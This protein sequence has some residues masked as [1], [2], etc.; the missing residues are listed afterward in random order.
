MLQLRRDLKQPLCL[1]SQHAALRAM[2]LVSVFMQSLQIKPV[3]S[4]AKDCR[5]LLRMCFQ[6]VACSLC[7]YL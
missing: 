5:Y 6:G 2:M 3:F 4:C 1:G 7:L